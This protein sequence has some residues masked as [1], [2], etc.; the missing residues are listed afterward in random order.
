MNTPDLHARLPLR[1]SHKSL[2]IEDK[3]IYLHLKKR[4]IEF[5]LRSKLTEVVGQRCQSTATKKSA[6]ATAGPRDRVPR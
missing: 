5:V 6:V 4:R 1:I 2:K 3:M